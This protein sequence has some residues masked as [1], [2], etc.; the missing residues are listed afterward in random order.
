MKKKVILVIIILII[1]IFLC[2]LG[3]FKYK[4]YKKLKENKRYEEIIS[5][6]EK[7]VI[8]ELD[9]TNLSSKKCEENI[10]KSVLLTT[11]YLNSQGYLDLDVMKDIDGKSYCKAYAK[12]FETEDCGVDYNI[13]IKC[14]NYETKGYAGWE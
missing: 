1:L 9:A 5:D 7:A 14:K 13:Y 2:S 12:T 6:F 11:K 10:S 4:E 8:W 3:F